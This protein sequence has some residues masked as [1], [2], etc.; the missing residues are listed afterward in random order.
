VSLTVA[1]GAVSGAA[2]LTVPKGWGLPPAPG[3]RYHWSAR[4]IYQRRT[5]DLLWD[6]MGVTG[7]CSDEERTAL[8]HWLD[9]KALPYLRWLVANGPDAP[10][11]DEQREIVVRGD[12]F[13]LRANPMSS[14]GY[15]YLSATVDAASTEPTP[16]P[17]KK[18]ARRQ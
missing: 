11:E 17:E 16:I 18:R 15:L 4:A 9:D 7:G 14:C 10:R 8:G 13:T 2:A 6:R 3:A 5:V 12:G 1:D